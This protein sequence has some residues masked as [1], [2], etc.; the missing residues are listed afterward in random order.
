MRAFLRQTKRSLSA[1]YV[2]EVDGQEINKAHTSATRVKI[3]S[4]ITLVRK[5]PLRFTICDSGGLELGCVRTRHNLNPFKQNY[6]DIVYKDVSAYTVSVGRWKKGKAFPVY[7]GGEQ[8]ALIEKS[9]VVVDN[10]DEYT[11]YALDSAALELALLLALYID[12][13]DYSNV[14]D[15]GTK[16]VSAQLSFSTS[17][18]IRDMYDASFKDRC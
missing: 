14:K 18:K 8:R 10:L 13:K 4:G 15:M 1:E 5:S 6:I 2:L 11:L 17:K 9:P 3:D 16:K 7:V 12:V